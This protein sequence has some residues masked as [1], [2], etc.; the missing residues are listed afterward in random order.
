M[1]LLRCLK[2]LCTC[3][4]LKSGV[5][6]LKMMKNKIKQCP[7]CE[8]KS[9]DYA[10]S[11]LNLIAESN[12]AFMKGD[13]KN[14]IFLP[15]LKELLLSLPASFIRYVFLNVPDT[16]ALICQNC[17]RYV[18]PCPNCDYYFTVPELPSSTKIY[19]CPNCGIGFQTCE[20]NDRFNRLLGK[21]V[22]LQWISAFIWGTIIAL[23][24]FLIIPSII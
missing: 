21:N 24:V 4:G 8:S 2:T 6:D 20:C 3:P 17:R 23:I 5:C 13:V 9:Y 1:N 15:L 18:L 7:N 10:Y 12:D 11:A 19:N 16:P 14:I 22:V